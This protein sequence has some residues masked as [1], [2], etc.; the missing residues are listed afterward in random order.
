MLNR[1][2]LSV[3]GWVWLVLLYAVNVFH[4]VA[5]VLTVV[6]GVRAARAS[7]PSR[8]HQP[9]FEML[10]SIGGIVTTWSSFAVVLAVM[11]WMESGRLL[12]HEKQAWR[13]AERPD[14]RR[15]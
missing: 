12:P 6:G 7:I 14:A 10:A 5:I 8:S 2:R 15:S 9:I 3:L 1:Q 4:I 13:E 11:I